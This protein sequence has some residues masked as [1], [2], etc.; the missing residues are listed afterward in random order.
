[1][2]DWSEDK[3]D[4]FFYEAQISSLCIGPD[5]WFW[6]EYF[7]VETYFGSETNIPTYFEDQDPDNHVDPPLGNVGRMDVPRFDPREYFLLK[8]E[9]RILQATKE[10]AALI[11]TFDA[12]MQDYV[13]ELVIIGASSNCRVKEKRIAD[14]FQDPHTTHTPILGN[15]ISKIHLFS[16]SISGIVDAW[17]TFHATQI[18]YFTT[19][20][21][22][23]WQLR[24]DK[25]AQNIAQLERLRKMLLNK[26]ERFE[27]KLRNAGISSGFG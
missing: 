10:Y 14:L 8:L 22:P 18:S 11:N 2:S 4:L 7:L 23:E 20:G 9:R 1:M 15:V 5:E 26:Q 27:C 12:R 6:T 13:S 19:F 25:I 17:E 24:I 16:G 3:E 21:K